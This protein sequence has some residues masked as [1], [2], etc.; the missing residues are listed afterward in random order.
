MSTVHEVIT[1]RHCE[2]TVFTFSLIT[3]HCSTDYDNDNAANHAE[4]IDVGKR[5][6]PLI[7]EFVSRMVLRI[8]EEINN[9]KK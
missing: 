2:M 4:V 3:N 8:A 1:A 5:R 9:K 6:Q 7:Q